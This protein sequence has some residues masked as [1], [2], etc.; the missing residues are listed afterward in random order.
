MHT[1]S[2]VHCSA[3]A[4][5][6]SRNR[7]DKIASSLWTGVSSADTAAGGAADIVAAP[8][9]DGVRVIVSAPCL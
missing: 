9:L 3:V 5:M 2:S 1:A 6:R 8:I 4:T 7:I